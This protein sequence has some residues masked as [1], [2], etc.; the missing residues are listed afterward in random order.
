MY[1]IPG[2]SSR[3][4]NDGTLADLLEYPQPYHRTA[5]GDFGLVSPCDRVAIGNASLGW[6]GQHR[7][8]FRRVLNMELISW[9]LLKEPYN[10]ITVILMTAFALLLLQ[11]IMPEPSS[12]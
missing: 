6:F 1:P 3:R 8:H 9:G 11:L 10:W 7:F 5:H 12:T 2:G 4:G